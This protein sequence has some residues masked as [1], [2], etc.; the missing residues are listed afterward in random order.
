MPPKHKIT[1]RDLYELF[2]LTITAT[3]TEIRQAYRKKALKCHP[4]KN[5]DNPKATQ[6]FLELSD[7]LLILLDPK[8]RGVY[9]Q[10]LKAREAAALRTKELDSKRR[11][12]KEDLE[13][14]EK[15]AKEASLQKRP[16]SGEDALQFEIE[17]LKKEGSRALLEE[18]ENIRQEILKENTRNASFLQSSV[19]ISGSALAQ[20][21]RLKI[22]WKSTHAISHDRLQTVASKYGNVT[23]L[24][25]MK[26]SALVEFSSQKEADDFFNGEGNS[27]TLEWVSKVIPNAST[28]SSGTSGSSGNPNLSKPAPAST[29]TNFEDFEAAILKNLSD[30]INTQK[31]Q[32]SSTTST[33]L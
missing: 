26:K 25:V 13:R 3:E 20:A 31:Q 11:K 32:S 21:P 10:T 19:P 12:L 33:A 18:Q 16:V 29:R 17:R 7:A 5:P 28:S 8:A 24:V 14:R 9:D 15:E 23:A 30:A 27:F 4:D 22:K 2:E 1:D 6:L